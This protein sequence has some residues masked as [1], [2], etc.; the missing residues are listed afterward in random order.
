VGEDA[1]ELGSVALHFDEGATKLG[2]LCS[3]GERLLEQAAEPILFALDSEEV[4][5]F[6]PGTR[7]RNLGVQEHASHYFVA[8]EP[9]CS[10]QIFE[11]GRVHVSEPHSDSTF[12][13]PHPMSISIAIALSRWNVV[14][15]ARISRRR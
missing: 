11:V 9:A 8:R 15:H 5:N 14:L 7:A 3:F 13:I 10:R 1:P 2:L 4:L 6:P 12:Q